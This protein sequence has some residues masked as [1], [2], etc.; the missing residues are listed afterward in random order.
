M[1]FSDFPNGAKGGKAVS[2]T[3]NLTVRKNNLTGK[4]INKK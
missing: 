3:S 4:I 2:H 1:S